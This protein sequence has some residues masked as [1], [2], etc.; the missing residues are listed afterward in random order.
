MLTTGNFSEKIKQ[1]RKELNLSVQ[2]MAVLLNLPAESIYKWQKG[3]RPVDLDHVRK[4]EM[5]TDGRFD[6]FVNDGDLVKN[7]DYDAAIRKI[8][9][10]K[11]TNDF[12][13][14]LNEPEVLYE[15]IRSQKQL[16]EMQQKRIEE[17]EEKARAPVIKTKTGG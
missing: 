17:L 11:P 5:F 10:P 13:T 7:Y 4:L 14:T 2:R 9:P 15:L 8:M 16:I 3:T 6:Q 1:K 12:A